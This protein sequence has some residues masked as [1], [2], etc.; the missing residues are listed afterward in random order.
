MLATVG[1]NECLLLRVSEL[2]AARQ[3]FLDK[4]RAGVSLVA[5]GN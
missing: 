1:S 5:P 4:R 3:A 2:H